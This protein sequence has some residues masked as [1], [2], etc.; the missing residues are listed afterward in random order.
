MVAE[1]H[2]V[3]CDV[4]GRNFQFGPQVYDGHVNQTYKIVV[5]RQ[6]HD[7]N[8]DGWASHLEQNV[9]KNLVAADLPLPRRNGKALL[10][11]E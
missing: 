2:M 9:T 1:K 4:C 11:R 10:P 8:W 7:A 5:C 6:C 3:K